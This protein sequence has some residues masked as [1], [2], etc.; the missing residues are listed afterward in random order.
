MSE[1]SDGSNCVSG[2]ES[3]G[4]LTTDA[5]PGGLPSG[6]NSA[7]GAH[8]SVDPRDALASQGTEAALAALDQ[9]SGE[10][11]QRSGPSWSDQVD[12]HAGESGDMDLIDNRDHVEIPPPSREEPMDS[13][14]QSAEDTDF[15]VVGN[16]RRDR[17]RR[18]RRDLHR[19]N[20]PGSSD[21]ESRRRDLAQS[22]LINSP[23]D[24]STSASEQHIEPKKKKKS[25]KAKETRSTEPDPA[26]LSSPERKERT[27]VEKS[28]R[29]GLPVDKTGK[30]VPSSKAGDST[31]KSKIPADGQRQ[32]VL[33]QQESKKDPSYPAPPPRGRD[34]KA[35][36]GRKGS[37]DRSRHSSMSDG[38]SD[39]APPSKKARKAS[40]TPLEKFKDK[41][42]KDGHD[43]R[44]HERGVLAHTPVYKA[45][46]VSP[47]RLALYPP[48]IIDPKLGEGYRCP[49]CP[50]ELKGFPGAAGIP[51]RHDRFYPTADTLDLHVSTY[52]YPWV[53]M[54]RCPR[55]THV[56]RTFMLYDEV[57]PHYAQMHPHEMHHV[58]GSID[59]YPVQL[60]L[61]AVRFNHCYIPPVMPSGG[62][63]VMSK[64]PALPRMIRVG[65]WRFSTRLVDDSP[66]NVGLMFGASWA[67][68]MAT[69]T[70]HPS[71]SRVPYSEAARSV[72]KE[73]LPPP[74]QR[75]S[76]VKSS[77]M[78]LILR[79]PYRSAGTTS[80][81][82]PG[83]MG[84]STP[85]GPTRYTTPAT[86]SSSELEPTTKYGLTVRKAK[87]SVG[88]S[89]STPADARALHEARVPG[90]QVE[91]LSPPSMS[92]PR[93]ADPPDLGPDV[94]SKSSAPRG[95]KDPKL[96]QGKGSRVLPKSTTAPAKVSGATQAVMPVN[97]LAAW[98]SLSAMRPPAANPRERL[99]SLFGDRAARQLDSITRE[100]S[101]LSV[102]PSSPYR[103]REQ[104]PTSTASPLTG[105]VD[106]L[107]EIAYQ[108]AHERGQMAPWVAPSAT[109]GQSAAATVRHALAEAEAAEAALL[110]RRRDLSHLALQMSFDEGIFLGAGT[111]YQ[112][113]PAG[114][115]TVR[116]EAFSEGFKA[117]SGARPPPQTSGLPSVSP[118]VLQDLR[119]A[120]ERVHI[121]EAL[122]D[123]ISR[124]Y[125]ALSHFVNLS[126]SRS[127]LSSQQVSAESLIFPALARYWAG[128]GDVSARQRE[129]V[130]LAAT[131][132]SVGLEVPSALP[133]PGASG[134]APVRPP[135]MPLGI[136]L[137]A[138]LRPGDP[139]ETGRSSTSSAPAD[140]PED[141]TDRS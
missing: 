135:T 56:T 85:T 12:L 46:S 134:S 88:S 99:T 113:S 51:L 62:P 81:V 123:D 31:G 104:R 18:E 65:P 112:H 83:Q 28:S 10:Q 8:A 96:T 91:G 94:R 27:P 122:Y 124:S 47:D 24:H 41:Y 61:G 80:T 59:D 141:I 20:S 21:E 131:C 45:T 15:Q 39:Q 30:A 100:L 4:S 129:Y 119:D 130:T 3:T 87:D 35:K 116:A 139:R 108:K 1:A 102:S 107:G 67:K 89:V 76:V 66:A 77:A 127:S 98:G 126:D 9:T 5:S 103:D 120:R 78:P 125:E 92:L 109:E 111:A 140:E 6:G 42:G 50:E 71:L 55:C 58:S 36:S 132:A 97:P 43:L 13:V 114:S 75:I 44:S 54:L 22:G 11:S 118:A 105:M 53:E 29:P 37:T 14:E 70:A 17:F 68:Q 82:T 69:H 57:R 133:V 72:P 117:G 19:D 115:D 64:D 40:Q 33:S 23:L 73:Q 90:I 74:E 63:W 26:L 110:A 2:E 128:S 38:K 84:P 101:Q 95:T 49:L 79:P 60:R 86:S 48:G 52:H 7:T 136:P 106:R 25:K 34:K 121:L 93:G 137:R 32:S 16:K 138:P